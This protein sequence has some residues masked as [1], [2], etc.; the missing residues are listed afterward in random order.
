MSGAGNTS[1]KLP[2]LDHSTSMSPRRAA[3]TISLA[4]KPRVAGTGK[5][6]CCARAAALCSV[7]A[8]PPGKAVA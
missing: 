3:S 4:S 1:R 8:A 6:H 2:P 7:T 5:P